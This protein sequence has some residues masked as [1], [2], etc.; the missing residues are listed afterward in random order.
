[1][2][3]IAPGTLCLHLPTAL[4]APCGHVSRQSPC[5]AQPR[6]CPGDGE[7]ISGLL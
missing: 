5:G 7:R 1:M 6:A 3:Q 4:G 2:L